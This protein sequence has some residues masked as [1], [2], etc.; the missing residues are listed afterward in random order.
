MI[1]LFPAINH[2]VRSGL[3]LDELGHG[4]LALP[5]GYILWR[6]TKSWRY[7]A[8]YFLSVYLI[9]LDHLF[10]YLVYSHGVLDLYEFVKLDYFYTKGTIYLIFHA[11][12]WLIPLLY[13]SIKRGW[14]S[15]ITAITLGIL[16]HLI[17]DIHNVEGRAWFYSIIFRAL[18]G[19]SIW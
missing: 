16:I 6:E 10:E 9:D 8:A 17:W 3:F 19:F 2:F 15:Y 12:E 5:V 18:R 11:W 4:L 7:V 1:N 14:K 13:I